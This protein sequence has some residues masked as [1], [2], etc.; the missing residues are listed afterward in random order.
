MTWIVTVV[1]LLGLAFG[2]W[3]MLRKHRVTIAVTRR[4]EAPVET[5]VPRC[6]RHREL[7]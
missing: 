6:F 2:S 1:G 5:V 7:P 4:I 3:A